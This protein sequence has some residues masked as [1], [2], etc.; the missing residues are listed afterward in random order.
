MPP[1]HGETDDGRSDYN[2]GFKKKVRAVPGACIR[3][4]ARLR[5]VA[6][7]RTRE[8][9]PLW[10]VP[11][12]P[13]RVRTQQVSLEHIVNGEQ[14]PLSWMESLGKGLYRCNKV[15]RPLALGPRL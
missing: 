7:S 5:H 1:A 6:L 9:L 2:S 8:G 15:R 13:R 12:P 14:T 10:R 3:R 11:H 4:T